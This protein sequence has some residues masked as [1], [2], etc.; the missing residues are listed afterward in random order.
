MLTLLE[1]HYAM[2][3]R[4]KNIIA[5]QTVLDKVYWTQYCNTALEIT[6]TDKLSRWVGFLQGVLFSNGLITVAA[7]RDY[8]RNLYKPVYE[9]MGVDSKTVDVDKQ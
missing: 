5:E 6:N 4:Y 2:I 7:E 8:S 9:S 1:V 3:N